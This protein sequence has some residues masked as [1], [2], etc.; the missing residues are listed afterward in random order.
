MTCSFDS[1]KSKY[2]Y[3]REKDCIKRLSKNLKELALEI[4]NYKEKEMI[5]LTNEEIDSY[6]KQNVSYIWQKNLVQIKMIKIHLKYTR[7]LEIT[8][9]TQKNLEELFVVFAI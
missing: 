9:I 4:I 5:P 1:T 7:R 6:E 3:Y 2:G 8:V